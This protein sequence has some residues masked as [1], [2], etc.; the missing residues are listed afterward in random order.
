MKCMFELGVAVRPGIPAWR[1]EDQSTRPAY[2]TVRSRS[3]QVL[4]RQSR[5]RR[6]DGWWMR[7]RSMGRKKGKEERE[8]RR[9]RQEKGG[10]GP[11]L[12]TI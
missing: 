7:R 10:E 8:R 12:Q 5:Y 9:G 4:K 6:R 1:W 3:R 11:L 2:T